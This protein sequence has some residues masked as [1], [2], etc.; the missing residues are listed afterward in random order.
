[1]AID[2][3]NEKLALMEWGVPWE[4]GIP[5][6]PGLFGQNDKQQL[7]WGYPGIF[8]SSGPLISDGDCEKI[9]QFVWEKLVEE[10]LITWVLT[11]QSIVML[12]KNMLTSLIKCCQDNTLKIGE[13]YSAI[14]D[15]RQQQLRG[16]KDLKK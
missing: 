5:I 10:G 13:L 4:P 9:A 16:G 11:I 1:M 3:T 14:R 12:N 6:T 2:N 15:I 7:L 8:W